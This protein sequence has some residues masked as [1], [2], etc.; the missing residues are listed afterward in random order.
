MR[1]P[2]SRRIKT[3]AGLYMRQYIALIDNAT[4][5]AYVL[6]PRSFGAVS[7]GFKEAVLKTAV[8]QGTEGSNPSC[9]GIVNKLR[10]EGFEA[11]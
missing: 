4:T 8:S 2:R 3:P 9:S 11:G 6:L 1:P 7:E 10:G 5:F